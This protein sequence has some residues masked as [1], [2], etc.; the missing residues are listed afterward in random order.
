MKKINE[1]KS[2]YKKA[3]KAVD[4]LVLLI[5]K[6]IPI[7][8][9]KL[10][11]DLD[12]INFQISKSNW[13]KISAMRPILAEPLKHYNIL[14]TSYN[15]LI[16]SSHSLNYAR[17]IIT[18]WV[19]NL[20]MND[21]KQEYL[22]KQ[23]DIASKE[24]EAI[25]DHIKPIQD[26]INY[27]ASLYDSEFKNSTKNST[28]KDEPISKEFKVEKIADIG[29]LITDL[30][31]RLEKDFIP[32]VKAYNKSLYKEVSK[33]SKKTLEPKG[34]DEL[35]LERSNKSYLDNY[36]TLRSR[37]SKFARK[38]GVELDNDVN[39][40]KVYIGGFDTS[41]DVIPKV[42]I[43]GYMTRTRAEELCTKYESWKTDLE[44]LDTSK[45]EYFQ[46][47]ML[48]EIKESF[49]LF[50]ESD[51]SNSLL[52]SYKNLKRLYGMPVKEYLLLSSRE[53]KSDI[54]IIR[55]LQQLEDEQQL[56]KLFDY[57]VHHLELYGNENHY[58][59][60]CLKS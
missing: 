31:D 59:T 40:T 60:N 48:P 43:G 45:I 1:I 53:G 36:I 51:E 8:S 16:G 44:S 9:D 52:E 2:S 7:I 25:I 21:T 6:T 56:Q 14:H 4:L 34:G 11:K 49:P 5:N 27:F 42:Y 20:K 54:N 30:I 22:N 13:T 41:S 35:T 33:V 38:G 55:Q 57:Y 50:D 12:H 10:F 26:S 32:T 37:I 18:K 29:K 3:T 23:I 47:V 17:K 39:L 46:K 58:P 15:V 24:L 19:I 28:K